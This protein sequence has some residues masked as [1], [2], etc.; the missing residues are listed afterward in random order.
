MNSTI[1]PLSTNND[2]RLPINSQGI[3]LKDSVPIFVSMT[4]TLD[5]LTVTNLRPSV[6]YADNA[7]QSIL[8]PLEQPLPRPQVYPHHLGPYRPFSAFPQVRP[9][10]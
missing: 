5:T 8:C 7:A 6:P 4:R 1:I 10:F 3:P 9:P 2:S